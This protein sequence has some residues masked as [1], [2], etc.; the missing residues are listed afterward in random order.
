MKVLFKVVRSHMAHE[1]RIGIEA[2][3]SP[4]DFNSATEVIIRG[5]QSNDLRLCPASIFY[6]ETN[7]SIDCAEIGNW[8][9]QNKWGHQPNAPMTLL[10]F[11]FFKLETTHIYEFV[12]KSEFYRLSGDDTYAI[13]VPDDH[14]K[15][16]IAW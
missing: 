14:S 5:I 15:L 2:S 4:I 9:T 6:N 1:F 13:D 10:K 16:T 11:E 7:K 8:I 12:G 3:S